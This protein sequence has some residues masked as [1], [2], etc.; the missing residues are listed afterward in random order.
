[1]DVPAAFMIRLVAKT[2]VLERGYFSRYC[3]R[4]ETINSVG[5]M[6]ML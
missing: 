2:F 5:L 6:V 3:G 4:P 1:M